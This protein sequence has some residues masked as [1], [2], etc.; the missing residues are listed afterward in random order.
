[1]KL[2]RREF[3]HP[4]KAC[5]LS[6]NGETARPSDWAGKVLVLAGEPGRVV[7]AADSL[8]EAESWVKNS[9]TY[10]ATACRFESGPPKNPLSDDDL[11]EF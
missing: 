3:D 8:Q 2:E 6:G 1:V 4:P 10:R 5:E 11:A 9:P 7:F